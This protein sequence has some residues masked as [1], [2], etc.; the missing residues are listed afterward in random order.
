[1]C[2]KTSSTERKNYLCRLHD[3]RS[4][5]CSVTTSQIQG[6]LFDPEFRILSVW[7]FACSLVVHVGFIQVLW[8]NVYT[9][10]CVKVCMHGLIHVVPSALNPVFPEYAQI[11]HCVWMTLLMNEC[12]GWKLFIMGEYPLS[13]QRGEKNDYCCPW[14]WFQCLLEESVTCI[15]HCV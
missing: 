11:I 13:A 12:K 15:K 10:D 4:V 14:L 3:F 5:A 8:M 7:S 9:N 6:P 1:M 2:L